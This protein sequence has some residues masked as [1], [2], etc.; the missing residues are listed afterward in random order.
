MCFEPDLD[1]KNSPEGPKKV[2]KRPK[3]WWN[4]KE[5]LI[6]Y[7]NRLQKCVLN[8]ISTKNSPEGPKKV[9]KRPKMWRNE[10]EKKIVLYFQKQS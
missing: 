6:V 5:K 3:M 4:Q 2:Q 7:I 8:L 10:K 1:P 9:R